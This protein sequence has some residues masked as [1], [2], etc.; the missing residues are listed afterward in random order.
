MRP[1]AF[2][3]LLAELAKLPG[4]GQRSA[5]R[6][7]FD[8]LKRAPADVLPLADAIRAVKT[9]LRAC[10]TCGNVTEAD[11]CPICSHPK[12]DRSVVLVVE[13]PLDIVSL[14][15]TGAYRG[16]YHVLMGRIAALDG[17]GPGE[18]N[19]QA[20][21]DRVAAPDSP[22]TEVILGTNPS[23]EG[24]GTALH[25][26]DLLADVGAQRGLKITR[27]ARGVPVNTTL[28]TV[29]KAVLSDALQARRS[30]DA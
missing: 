3:R 10:S 22:I 25:L 13:Q 26:A 27:L 28:Q 1:S 24:D 17:V 30:V 20:L 9:D 19:V 23:L 7:A 15:A 12:R 8:L 14:E 29:S 4:V 18:L 2:D 11:P 5:E 16:L 21:L 6:I